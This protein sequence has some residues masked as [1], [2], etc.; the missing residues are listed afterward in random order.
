V[1]DTNNLKLRH[2]TWFAR[3]RVPRSLH[4]VIGRTELLRSLKTRD[5]SEARRRR[6]RVV[7]ALQEE[8]SRLE[9]HATMPKGSVEFVVE[10]AKGQR[11]AVL[12]G[13]QSE[14]MAEAGLDATEVTPANSTAKE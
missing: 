3:V 6:H 4:K 11:E 1:L 10:A 14:E 9:A 8:L 5:L 7:A 13:R 12:A 2:R